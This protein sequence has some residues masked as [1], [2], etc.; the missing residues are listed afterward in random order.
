[1]SVD[2]HEYLPVEYS[3]DMFDTDISGDFPLRVRLQILQNAV[4]KAVED[5]EGR[6]E[7]MYRMKDQLIDLVSEMWLE[8]G[9]LSENL[10][11]LIRISSVGHDDDKEYTKSQ[12][13][14][15]VANQLNER[16]ISLIHDNL[17]A[18]KSDIRELSLQRSQVT[19]TNN[20][21]TLYTSSLYVYL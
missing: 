19:F 7:G 17:A 11:M 3:L 21:P 13:L 4:N 14:A 16:N 2:I 8:V 12:L 1:M 9:S 10:Q 18:W 6:S 15:Q 20:Y 5:F